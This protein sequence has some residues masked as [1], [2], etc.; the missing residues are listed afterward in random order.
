MSTVAQL[1]EKQTQ[2]VVSSPAVGHVDE[3]SKR[4][5]YEALRQKLGASRLTVVG[6]PGRH[7]FW[8]PLE[9]RNEQA[10]LDS[11]GYTIVREPDAAAVLAGKAQPKIK[12]NGLREDGT[13]CL[14]D[15]ILMECSEETYEFIMLHN[16]ERHEQMALGAQ[17]DF[18]TEAERL[19]VPVFDKQK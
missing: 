14:G 3:V 10:R 16:S 4:A 9:D 1:L 18:R 5:R 19:A 6:H 2:A 8:G 15:V 12:A 7:Y 17:R 11:I 13:Y